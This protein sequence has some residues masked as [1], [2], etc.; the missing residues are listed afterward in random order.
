MPVA[1]AAMVAV[2]A[3]VGMGMPRPMRAFGGE[4]GMAEAVEMMMSHGSDIKS[5]ISKIKIYRECF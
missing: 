1:S 5:D 4:E 2:P 3:M